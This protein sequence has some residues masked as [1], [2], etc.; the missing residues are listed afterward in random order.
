[1]TKKKFIVIDEVTGETIDSVIIAKPKYF[2]LDIFVKLYLSGL[3][4]IATMRLRGETSRV[5]F[6]LLS[7]CSYNNIINVPQKE[8]AE[9]L[10]IKR[11][12]VS[13][14]IK[15]LLEKDILL[16]G[17][18]DGRC[19]T[20]RL[21]HALGSKGNASTAPGEYKPFATNKPKKITGKT[22]IFVS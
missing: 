15:E 16:P 7:R 22:S 12:S 14:A 9:A 18:K 8:I 21:N 20:Y 11:Q 6:Y 1:M 5:L 3:A 4:N 13:K 19:N 2:N 10:E 17:S